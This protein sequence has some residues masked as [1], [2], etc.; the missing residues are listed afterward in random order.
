[1]YFVSPDF[2]VIELLG[3]RADRPGRPF[4]V[5]FLFHLEPQRAYILS[6]AIWINNTI[7][8]VYFV[9]IYLFIWFFFFLLSFFEIKIENNFSS[10]LLYLFTIWKKNYILIIDAFFFLKP[11]RCRERIALPDGSNCSSWYS[12][13]IKK[14]SFELTK[15][16]IISSSYFY[17]Q[18]KL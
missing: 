7:S 5:R 16:N 12:K 17:C 2:I 4:A 1:M 13:E 15:E 18:L 3:Q 9:S 8:L 14:M 10:I 6:S 11:C